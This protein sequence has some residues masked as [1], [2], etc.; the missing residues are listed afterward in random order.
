MIEEKLKR[1][2]NLYSWHEFY[3]K[4]GVYNEEKAAK[5]QAEIVELQKELYKR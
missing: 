4:L 3:T 1:L 2:Q 5:V